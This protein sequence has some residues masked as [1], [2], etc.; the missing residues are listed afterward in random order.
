MAYNQKPETPL[1]NNG[2]FGKDKIENRK[3]SEAKDKD[4][5]VKQHGPRRIHNP[6]KPITF[7]DGTTISKEEFVRSGERKDY[8]K[9]VAKSAIGQAALGALGFL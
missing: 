9:R 5:T 1:T 6:D 8:N 7:E 2:E 3:W 4:S